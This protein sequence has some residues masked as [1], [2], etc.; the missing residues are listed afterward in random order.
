MVGVFVAPWLLVPSE[1][2]F[3]SS[4]GHIIDVKTWCDNPPPPRF[5]F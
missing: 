5:K 3:A 4:K 2:C 1:K